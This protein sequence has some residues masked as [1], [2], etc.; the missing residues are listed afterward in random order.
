MFYVLK[1]Q[2]CLEI[3]TLMIFSYYTVTSKILFPINENIL[4]LPENSIHKI[5][6]C[7]YQVFCMPI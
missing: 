6:M 4:Q 1:G 2:V 7:M 5:L 3:H